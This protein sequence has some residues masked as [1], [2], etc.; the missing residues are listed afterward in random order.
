MNPEGFMLHR[1]SLSW[2]RS[3]DLLGGLAPL[4]QLLGSLIDSFLLR[5]SPI[6]SREFATVDI[7]AEKSVTDQVFW[8]LGS[9][10]TEPGVVSDRRLNLG[11]TCVEVLIDEQ[12][13][14]VFADTGWTCVLLRTEVTRRC[15]LIDVWQI[16][17]KVF[18]FVRRRVLLHDWFN[19]FFRRVFY[20]EFLIVR[21]NLH[22]NFVGY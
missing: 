4:N 21:V 8:S 12:V 2:F 11:Q 16:P 6:H 13:F 7:E 15:G 22:R 17:F 19:I 9:S 14:E 1:S 10:L 18:F 3:Q 5:A 20:L